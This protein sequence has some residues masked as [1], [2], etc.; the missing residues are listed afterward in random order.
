M[1]S[2]QGGEYRIPN[3]NNCILG[4]GNFGKVYL[5]Y[6]RND[7][8]VAIKEIPKSKLEEHP[9]IQEA[10]LSEI[11]TQKKAT[12]SGMPYFVHLITN[13]STD[14][15]EYVV[16]EF[17]Q[18]GTLTDYYKKKKLTIENQL[19][20]IYQ[21][22]I[23]VEYLH[24]IGIT[25]RDLK[26]DNILKHGDTY[27]I[28]DFGFA[29][30]KSVLAT[31]LGTGYYM[32]PELVKEEEYDRRVDVWAMNT[33]LYRMLTKTYFFDGRT[34][35]QLDNNIIN[36][37]FR[38]PSRFKTWPEDVKDLLQR[39][40]IKDFRKRPTMLEYIEHQAFDFIK[41]K[42]KK[43]V[44][45]VSSIKIKKNALS[46]VQ[47][48]SQ[49]QHDIDPVQLENNKIYQHV[50]TKLVNYINNLKP[51]FDLYKKIKDKD[52]VMGLVS[53]KRFIQHMTLINIFFH[54]KKFSPTG[55]FKKSNI[56]EQEWDTFYSFSASKRFVIRVYYH[57]FIC[58]REY[59]AGWEVLE[60]ESRKNNVKNPLEIEISQKIRASFLNGLQQVKNSANKTTD[61]VMIH[62][63]RIADE[64]MKLENN[65]T[66][67]FMTPNP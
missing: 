66:Y 55:A 22:G 14:E 40:Y 48:N 50:E 51:F 2:L 67:F 49:D 56:T 20:I 15:Y 36:Q 52:L 38:V 12:E 37:K 9:Y 11:E 54:N 60:N 13:F 41:Q 16:L 18:G 59:K 43:N 39:G 6:D 23:G 42:H 64:I 62:V 61:P 26:L 24:R 25:H 3:D 58:I 45:Y 34:R 17:C 29:T 28:A 19:E 35:N 33:I 1:K 32:S 47:V 5:A 8:K 10:F 7:N 27:K 30:E 57:L 46:R 21:V 65:H 31:C 63:I 53:L 44:D 4:A